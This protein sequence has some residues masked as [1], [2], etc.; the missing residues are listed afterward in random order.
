MGTASGNRER[1]PDRDRRSAA[2]ANLRSSD[3]PEEVA[4]RGPERALPGPRLSATRV[5]GPRV[6]G[7]IQIAEI[8]RA[9]SGWTP[10]APGPMI[11]T[12]S[13]T[14]TATR[15]AVRVRWILLGL[16][17]ELIGTLQ[18]R[19]DE[20]QGPGVVSVPAR[21]K[22]HVRSLRVRVAAAQQAAGGASSVTH[23]RLR[24]S[25]SPMS[26]ET[27]LRRLD[28]EQKTRRRPSRPWRTGSW[29]VGQSSPLHPAVVS[30]RVAKPAPTR[31]NPFSLGWR[32]PG[33]SRTTSSSVLTRD[34]ARQGVRGVGK[35]EAASPSLSPF[36]A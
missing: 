13:H 33:S 18:L 23:S 27:P 28:G 4:E 5:P 30:V 24:T 15:L 34:T 17:R 1:P 6:M 31:S 29:Q 2:E 25:R 8:S 26:S 21:W 7:R 19:I 20:A 3:I 10:T 14:T 12:S 32:P 36:R 9:G 35:R 22:S 16:I 11:A